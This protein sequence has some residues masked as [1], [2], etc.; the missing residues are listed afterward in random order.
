MG[1]KSSKKNNVE[2][3]QLRD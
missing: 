2:F 3:N 1:G